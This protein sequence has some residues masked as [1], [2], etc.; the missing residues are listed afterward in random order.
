MLL[1]KRFS[2]SYLMPHI[3]RG[4]AIVLHIQKMALR[5]LVESRL[6]KCYHMEGARVGGIFRVTAMLFSEKAK[7]IQ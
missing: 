3:G 4:F 5:A 7:G 2:H 1:S 6:G